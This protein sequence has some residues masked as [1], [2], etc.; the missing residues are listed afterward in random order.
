[1]DAPTQPL[2][3]AIAATFSAEA[4]QPSL[5]FWMD[6]LELPARFAFAAYN[7]LFQ[8]L[9]DPASVLSAN[10][11]GFN[12][13][14][15]RVEDWLAADPDGECAAAEGADPCAD[16]RRK[17]ADFVETLAAAVRRSSAS[18]MLVGCPASPAH[19]G[20]SGRSRLFAEMD[21]LL[22]DGLADVPGVDVVTSAELAGAY[23]VAEY[24]DAH[25]NSVA[26]IPYTPRFFAALGTMVARRI[27]G[28]TQPVCKA[29]VVDC[30]NTLWTGACGEDGPDGVEVDSGRQQ[31]HAYLSRL[32]DS[33]V[34]LCLCS[35]N[36]EAD[37]R[38]V[39]R[40]RPEMRIA[41][42][43]FAAFRS[44]WRPKSENIRSIAAELDLSPG[45]FAFF[46]DDPVECAEVRANCPQVL[47]IPLP[48][49]SAAAARF[50]PNLW[51]FDGRKTTAEGRQRT[52]F[53]RQNAARVRAR[54]DA[55][56]LSQFLARLDLMIQMVDVLPANTP[57]LS[58]L[59]RRT[60]Q[61]NLTTIRRTEA[62]ID[63]LSRQ[64]VE[65]LAVRVKDRFGDY[66]IVGLLLFGAGSD[67]LE[68]D[69]FL[70]SC[71]ALGRG[72][73]HRMLARLGEIAHER[74]LSRVDLPFRRTAGNQPALDFLGSVATEYEGLQDGACLFRI[75]ADV[76]STTR[77]LPSEHG[78][79]A[80][81]MRPRVESVESPGTDAHARSALLIA[82]ANDLSDPRQ[83]QEQIAARTRARPDTGNEYVAPRNSTE[84][85]I[86]GILGELLGFDRIGVEDNFF[87]MGGH[88]LL[89]MQV[90]FRIREAFGVELSAKDLYD[91]DFTSAQ[92]AMK[93]Q[94]SRLLTAD[95]ARV[96]VLIAK[97][98]RLSDKEIQTLL[99]E[100]SAMP[101]GPAK[102]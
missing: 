79:A 93:V 4:I 69:T 98:D 94:H 6:E 60:N 27:H 15:L 21:A 3:L 5:A 64:G 19:E 96:D 48:R 80:E 72:V 18:W 89:A 59:T 29:V 17:V 9:L 65:G 53:Y 56:T 46:D 70:L 66:G 55:P 85:T 32:H 100:S 10:T 50:V 58:E 45:A 44:N 34:L 28:R 22:V 2:R 84:G 39:F 7:Q 38:A 36:N 52:V 102:Q 33:G 87:S 37:V 86:A 97:L 13:V 62:E 20:G 47:I 75:P 77:Y 90:I 41:L 73:E 43:A 71:R 16:L 57:R 40:H 95:T 26:H 78:A 35:R 12:I 67:A 92:L 74:G 24:F 11:H 83:V 101:D 25:A 61:F 68:I 99:E 8:E 14:L 82:I 51:L 81:A 30:D 54:Q 49:E 42:D 91:G 88:S 31:I 76:A 1:M 63:A 23:P